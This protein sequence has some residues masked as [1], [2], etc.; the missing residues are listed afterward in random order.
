MGCRCTDCKAANTSH[1][2]KRQIQVKPAPL[3]LRQVRPMTSVELAWLA[4]LLEGEGSFMMRCESG[5]LSVRISLQ[6][7]DEDVVR[8][9]HA[10]TGCGTVAFCKRQKPH[11][12]DTYRWGVGN[13]AQV[14]TLMRWLYPFM[15]KRRQGQMDRCLQAVIEIGGPRTRRRNHGLT[16]YED[17]CRC[18]ICYNA[19]VKVNARRSQ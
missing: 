14:T 5:L 4:G 1:E 19:K 18:D 16:R 17:G 9:A 7:T 11:H 8:R 15:G 13:M 3:P 10:L 6:M 12:K 2:R